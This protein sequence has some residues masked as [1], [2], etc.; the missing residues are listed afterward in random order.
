M[1]TNE[2]RGTSPHN[3]ASDIFGKARRSLKAVPVK[4]FTPK[5]LPLSVRWLEAFGLLWTIIG[6]FVI[7]S[8]LGLAG[9]RPASS[10]LAFIVAVAG[11]IMILTGPMFCAAYHVAKAV[12][13]IRDMTAHRHLGD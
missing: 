4:Q 9:E 7:A 5:R 6:I 2:L 1:T 12:L 8:G 13:H 11:L 3:A 10:I